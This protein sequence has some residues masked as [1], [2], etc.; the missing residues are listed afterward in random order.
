MRL[1]VII[2]LQPTAHRKSRACWTL[3]NTIEEEEFTRI[4]VLVLRHIER[5]A[6]DSGVGY[7]GNIFLEVR[8]LTGPFCGLALRTCSRGTRLASQTCRGVPR[9][10]LDQQVGRVVLNGLP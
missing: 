4:V 5:E 6:G 7:Y 8:S 10:A 3:L 1:I 2:Y 9:P